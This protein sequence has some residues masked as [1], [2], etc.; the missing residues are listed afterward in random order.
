[1]FDR[2]HTTSGPAIT[3]MATSDAAMRRTGIRWTLA[4]M[5][6]MAGC[7]ACG[8]L[9]LPAIASASVNQT[10]SPWAELGPL[11]YTGGQTSQVTAVYSLQNLAEPGNTMLEDNDVDSGNGALTNVWQ[12]GP[13]QYQDPDATSSDAQILGANHLW[14]FVPESNNTT[15][16]LTSGYGELMNRQSGLCLDLN[17]SDPNEYG[18][19]AI[20]DQWSCGG[21]ANQEWM[22]VWNPIQQGYKLESAADGGLL[23]V[24][25]SVVCD[26]QGNGDRVYLRTNIDDNATA[27]NAWNIQQASYDFA[28]YALG[29]S[30]GDQTDN[31]SY[32]CVP[33]DNLRVQWYNSDYD[34]TRPFG[35]D[36]PSYPTWS[37]DNDNL[38][39]ST[40]VPND[41]FGQDTSGLVDDNGNW[42]N[43]NELQGG[44]M[45]YTAS[46][47]NGTGQIMLYC[48]PSSTNP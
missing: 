25:N 16:L 29:V 7:L 44:E 5:A 26:A 23:G 46:S 31:R 8:L 15:G 3:G 47:A 12:A 9:A 17:G 4:R 35:T 42:V 43:P 28:T 6:A 22:A 32:E 18:D 34:A 38:G 48:D 30:G 19:G 37:Y 11:A 14:E 45:Y 20:V 24:G 27:C 33:S 1:M 36:N 10:S 39:S 40:V 2:R 41:V 13:G 21:G